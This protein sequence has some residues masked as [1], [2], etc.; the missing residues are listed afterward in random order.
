M[1]RRVLVTRLLR[2]ALG[3]GTVFWLPVTDASAAAPTSRPNVV[4]IMT[5]QQPVTTIG[6][7]GNRQIKTPNLDRLAREGMR[8]EQFHIAAFACSPSRASFWTGQWSH[9]H[10]VVSNDIVLGG[11]VPTLGSIARAQGYQSAF[12]GKWHLGG[13]MYVREAK[14]RWSLRRVADPQGFAYEKTG[15]WR[16]GEDQPQ[17]GFL[18]KWVGGWEQFQAHL[19]SVELGTFLDRKQRV[20][21]HNMAPSGIEGTHIYSQIPA[22]QHEVAFLAREAEEFIRYQR[23]RSKPFC[24]VLSFYGPHLPVAPPQPWDTMYD[25][26]QVPL[27]ENFRDDLTGK[28]GIQRANAH[29]WKAGQ[30]TEAQYRDYIARYW[31]YCSYIDERVG[32]VLAALDAEGITDDTIIVFT[33]DHGD[34]LAAHGFIYKLLSGY[35]ELM[36]IPFIIRYPRVV[37]PDARCAAMVQSIDVLPTLLDL[38]ALAAPPQIDGRSFRALLD[39]KTTEF[40][41][42]VLTIMLNTF[43]LA[44]RD[45]K[46]VYT[47]GREPKPFVELYDRHSRPLEVKNLAG[48]QDRAA[49]LADMQQRLIAQLRDAGYPYAEV[50]AERIA[51]ARAGMP[52]PDEMVW[53]TVASFKP[54]RDDDGKLFAEFSVEWNVGQ[55]LQATAENGL[56][57]YWNSIQ[58]LGGG[59]KSIITRATLWPDPPTTGWKLGTKQTVGPVRVPI[60]AHMQGDYAVRISLFSPQTKSP[61]P[62]EGNAQRIV[63]TVTIHKDAQGQQK[64]SFSGA[65]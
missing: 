5:D 46:L 34:M 61:P 38:C 23:D 45:W 3:C 1:Q 16:G 56:V 24:L 13:N 36:R 60:P 55:P 7:Y 58:L 40:R 29:A 21:N 22:E 50:V 51:E 4:F 62:V 28:P 63:G 25:P 43:M 14:D 49:V 31:G 57:K 30:W 59:G 47:S 12:L 26:Q 10:G 37:R 27:P 44:T 20:G 65:K 15:P 19:H 8:F 32:R 9:H 11:E 6:A 2:A 41:E 33:T 54:V 48:D 35:D 18:D 39:G 17:C 53:P 52:G 42:Q 64:L